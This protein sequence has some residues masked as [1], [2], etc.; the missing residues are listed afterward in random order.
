[1]NSTSNVRDLQLVQASRLED[2][3]LK[4]AVTE[5]KFNPY[6][7]G[8][9]LKS[10]LSSLEFA[11]N[12]G[13]SNATYSAPSLLRSLDS[14]LP[15]Y[16]LEAMY[17]SLHDEDT[18]LYDFL[19][20]FDHRLIELRIAVEKLGL[21]ITSQ[22]KTH[23]KSKEQ[24]ALHNIE[25]LQ[26]LSNKRAGYICLLFV[27]LNGS[28]SLSDLKQIIYWLTGR[29]ARVSAFFNKK[30]IIDLEA[31]S[32]ISTSKRS[33]NTLGAGTILGKKG[34][35]N[36][37]RIVITF[38]CQNYEEF[39]DVKNC[40]TINKIMPSVI[41]QYFRNDIFASIFAELE[42]RMFDRPILSRDIKKSIRLGE[43]NCLSHNSNST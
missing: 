42:T 7:E 31:R 41:K 9:F 32:Y 19:G 28:R 38:R 30:E 26:N 2:Q 33:N 39:I 6:P 40:M 29:R 18:S 1:M 15:D 24:T 8:K 36:I 37:G 34:V 43:Y 22:D 27:L 17:R 14:L 21:L 10:S 20:I 13:H 11:D 3:R 25:K 23:N 12:V 4:K 35:S 5:G 16:I